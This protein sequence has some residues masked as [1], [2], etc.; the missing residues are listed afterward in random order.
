MST[1]INVTVG[2]GGLPEKAKQQ[3]QA[4]RQ[5][6]LE[7]ERQQRIQTQG[8]EQ[9]NAALAAEGTAPDGSLL[10]GIGARQA[11]TQPRPAAFRSGNKETVTMSWVVIGSNNWYANISSDFTGTIIRA[12]ESTYTGT[13]SGRSLHI[14]ST[15]G[16]YWHSI[17]NSSDLKAPA[18]FTPGENTSLPPSNETYR[19][20]TGINNVV[21]DLFPVGKGVFIATFRFVLAYQ[22]ACWTFST[23]P[24][25]NYVVTLNQA[26]P[27]T[28]IYKSF[29]V[30]KSSVKEITTPQAAKDYFDNKFPGLV[31]TSK[32]LRRYT[33]IGTVLEQRTT[34][35]P[36]Y[37]LLNDWGSVTTFDFVQG[38]FNR[39]SR[40][41]RLWWLNG[42]WQN[43]MPTVGGSLSN[44]S[45]LMFGAPAVYSRATNA[46]TNWQ[47]YFNSTDATGV[48][49][50]DFS[51]WFSWF[52]N[53]YAQD[54]SKIKKPL[55][56]YVASYSNLYS[57]PMAVQVPFYQ[58]QTA[59]PV[60]YDWYQGVSPR[61]PPTDAAY[62]KPFITL[63]FANN[64][65]AM[66][67]VAG[68]QSND[69]GSAGPDQYFCVTTDWGEPKYCQQQA[70]ALGF[71][72]ADLTP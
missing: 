50:N 27:I 46:T 15:D 35:N 38:A 63:S 68:V 55:A 9:R 53:S 4:A 10:Y 66:P 60:A 6:Q 59:M 44:N 5:A 21:F 17:V 13:N 22:K 51:S 39:T 72:L 29:L 20:D 57:S 1:Q 30:S 8:Q 3:Q 7:K 23:P 45:A 31:Q 56:Y 18:G 41:P 43:A 11:L 32:T 16:T 64:A 69:S 48:V 34:P 58:A 26:T 40:G 14:S 25:P 36:A 67:T 42:W 71:T 37:T 49:T 28:T 70:L 62:W 52:A 47:N 54:Q 2:S 65:Q 61:V 24:I 12:L 33:G 19:L